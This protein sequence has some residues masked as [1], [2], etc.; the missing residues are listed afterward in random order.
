MAITEVRV[1][2]Q[3]SVLPTQDAINAQWVTQV[4]R[5]GEVI[6]ETTDYKSYS[7]DKAAEFSNDVANASHYMAVLGWTV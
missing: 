6:N 7:A 3:V 4:M 2:K 1:L 5:D